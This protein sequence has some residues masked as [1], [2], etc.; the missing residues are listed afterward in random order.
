MSQ[1]RNSVFYLIAVG[2]SLAVFALAAIGLFLPLVKIDGGE[3]ITVYKV[4]GGIIDFFKNIKEADFDKVLGVIELLRDTVVVGMAL[5]LLLK[6][7]LCFIKYV[8]KNLR[9]IFHPNDFYGEDVISVSVQVALFSM[10]L[11]AYYPSWEY[12]VGLSLMSVGAVL[13][14]VIVSLLRAIEGLKSDNKVRGFLHALFMFFAAMLFFATIQVGMHS[15]VAPS[16]GGPRVALVNE[17]V[18]YFTHTF[19]NF[20]RDNLIALILMFVALFL[21]FDAFKCIG[22]ACNYSLGCVRKKHKKHEQ[23]E[24]HFRAIARGLMGLGFLAGSVVLIIIKSKEAF[25]RS[26]T[27]GRTGIVS[28]I[29]LVVAIVCIIIAK[30]IRPKVNSYEKAEEKEAAKEEV[31]PEIVSE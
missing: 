9:N 30:R 18:S 1:N 7:V 5:A 28:A 16:G 3:S 27:V 14:I 13:G 21:I 6:I 10:T 17:F 25:G 11:Y 8:F 20:S 19:M 12:D 29:F 15:L 24:Y 4:V 23:K 26:Y 2:A 22:T 31:E